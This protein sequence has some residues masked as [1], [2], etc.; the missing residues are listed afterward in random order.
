MAEQNDTIA[1]LGG[2]NMAEALLR[3]LLAGG[4]AQAQS[5]TVSDVSEDRLRHLAATYGVRTAGRNAE[6][7]AAGQT[8]VVAVKPGLVGPVLSECGDL[9][10]KLVVSI[11]AGVSM[12][13]LGAAAAGAH[14]VRVMP[15]TPSLVGA[16][17][18]VFFAAPEVPPAARE[19][20]RDLLGAVGRVAEVPQES[21][22]D[23]VT[24]LSGSGPAYVFLFLEALADGGVRMGLP[25]PLAR[26]LAAQTVFGA[27]K[28]ALETGT[29]PGEL[30]DQVTSPGGTTIAGIAAL[31]AAGFRSAV[32]EAVAA[33][34]RR[35]REL[36]NS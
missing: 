4:S 25:R 29:H 27:A 18:S 14:V 15:N 6:A 30:K 22:L 10:G 32:L 16:G 36:G 13:A 21:L 8:L 17:M 7:A 19:R 23:A 5:I 9:T 33:A 11:A 35:S 20:T 28:L 12:A 34:T 3:G 24:G 2:G 1:F 26:E 31:E